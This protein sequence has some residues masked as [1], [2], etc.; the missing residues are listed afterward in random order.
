MKWCNVMERLLT[1]A[2]SNVHTSK[3]ERPVDNSGYPNC[4]VD[5]Y[6]NMLLSLITLVVH[7]RDFPKILK[8]IPNIIKAGTLNASDIIII[9]FATTGP[10]TKH[11]E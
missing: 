9:Q 1:E 4:N 10:F 7:N 2:K 5:I 8:L 3:R 6:C 11:I